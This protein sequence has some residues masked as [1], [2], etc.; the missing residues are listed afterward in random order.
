MISFPFDS[1]I[2]SYDADGLPVY[3]RAANASQL[4]SLLSAY[5][6]NGI[7]GDVST[8]MQVLQA[9]GMAVTVKAGNGN[10]NGAYFLE[11][12]DRTL[13]V[14][15]AHAT[16][17]RIDTVVA[18]LDMGLSVR[19]IDLY[20]VTGIAAATPAAPALT[21]DATQWELGL[22]NLYI[23]ANATAIPQSRITD[24][25]TDSNRCGIVAQAI[26]TLDTSAY[27]AQIQAELAAFK[28]TNEAAFTSWFESVQGT[29]GTDSAG[30][31][32]NL[33]RANQ[34]ADTATALTAAGWT[35]AG[36]Y[37]QSVSVPGMTADKKAF[38]GLAP[39]AT[40]AQSEAAAMAMLLCTAQAAGSVTVTAFGEKPAVALPLLVRIVG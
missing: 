27:Y 26:T 22:A 23:T 33:I 28:A 20:V 12:S 10:I 40:A 36:P 9:S 32:L 31:L 21:R 6:S 11:I 8:K 38:A 17:P 7:F 16:L 15:A 24:T 3:D 14:Q 30:N 5:F 1:Q 39:T 34:A 37:T 2:A 25:R 4:R 18:R 35:G 19:S 13:T 29:L